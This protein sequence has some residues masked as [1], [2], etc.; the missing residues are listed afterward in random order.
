MTQLSEH[1]S[2]EEMTA[3]QTAVRRGLNNTPTASIVST[4]KKTAAKMEL[5]RALLGVGIHVS[6]AYRSPSVN[7]AIGGA[8]TSQHCKGEAIDFTAP[9]FGT[10]REVAKAI[11]ASG[12]EFDQLIFEGTW[13]HVSFSDRPRRNVLTAVF[14]SGATAYLTGIA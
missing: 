6:S 1:F 13:V 8:S 14:R 5:V 2:L 4:L 12:I 11:A 7:R 10:P 9:Q 3:S